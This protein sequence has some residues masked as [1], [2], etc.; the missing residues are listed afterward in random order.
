VR[1]CTGISGNAGRTIAR[2]LTDR[3]IETPR[4]GAWQYA[5]GDGR[6]AHLGPVLRMS[7]SGDALVTRKNY[8]RPYVWSWC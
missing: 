3:G 1:A 2:E 4:G 6:L 5:L 8:V 7:V